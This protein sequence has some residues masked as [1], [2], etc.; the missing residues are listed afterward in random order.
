VL[1][2]FEPEK[3]REG[4]RNVFQRKGDAIVDVNIKAFDAGLEF[5]K[6]KK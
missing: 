5:A 6:N 1:G 3:I 2:I 4:I